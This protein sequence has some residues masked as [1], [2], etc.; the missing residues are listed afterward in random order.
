V[1]AKILLKSVQLLD[2]G[3]GTHRFGEIA[4]QAMK[5]MYFEKSTLKPGRVAV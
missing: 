4:F 1:V 5:F 2:P 3:G